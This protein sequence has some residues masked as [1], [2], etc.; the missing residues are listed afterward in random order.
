MK[1]VY[2]MMHSQKNIKSYQDSS[3][4]SKTSLI[5]T[6]LQIVQWCQI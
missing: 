6:Q 2:T 1:Q 3:Q 5:L 4:A